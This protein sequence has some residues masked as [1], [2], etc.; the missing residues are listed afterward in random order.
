MHEL[1][2]SKNRVRKKTLGKGKNKKVY[3]YILYDEMSAIHPREQKEQILQNLA[4]ENAQYVNSRRIR[5]G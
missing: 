5:I 2:A 1:T 4:H 3:S